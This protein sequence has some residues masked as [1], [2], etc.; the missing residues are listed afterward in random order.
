[1]TAGA[2][3]PP[4]ARTNEDR[5]DRKARVAKV[6]TAGYTADGGQLLAYWQVVGGAHGVNYMAHGPDEPVIGGWTFREL[7]AIANGTGPNVERVRSIEELPPRPTLP[8]W[9]LDVA[10]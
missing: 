1:M 9:V 2:S 10:L 8:P 5:A 7:H 3:L 4:A 6:G